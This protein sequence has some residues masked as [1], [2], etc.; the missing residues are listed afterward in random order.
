MARLVKRNHFKASSFILKIALKNS[1]VNHI[2]K[3]IDLFSA[4]DD[5]VVASARTDTAKA[6][7]AFPF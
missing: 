4:E 5:T 3:R 2:W 6:A 1:E 7:L